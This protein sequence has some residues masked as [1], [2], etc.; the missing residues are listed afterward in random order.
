MKLKLLETERKMNGYLYKIV[1]RT[2][3]M[4][5][6]KVTNLVRNKNLIGYEVWVIRITK[7]PEQWKRGTYLGFDLREKGPSEAEFGRYGWFYPNEKIAR[8]LFNSQTLA[9]G[10][11]NLAVEANYSE[12]G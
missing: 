8:G 6:V 5:L 2:K 1:E 4:A 3:T 10:A 12:V 11:D 9:R 7:I